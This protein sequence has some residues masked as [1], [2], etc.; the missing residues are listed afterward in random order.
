MKPL[1]R[2]TNLIAALFLTSGMCGWA[3]DIYV[4]N[5][6]TAEIYKVDAQGNRTLFAATASTQP[7]GMAF[8]ARGNLYVSIGLGGIIQ[9]FDP[10]G[11][12]ST[13]GNAPLNQPDSLAFDKSGNLY[14]AN[15]FGN[16]IIKL[17]PQGNWSV[18]SDFN[19]VSAA[20][21]LAFDSKGNLFGAF[22]GANQLLKFDAYGNQ[23]L[24]AWTP[25][26][27]YYLTADQND[28]LYASSQ[29][30]PIYKIDPRGVVSTFVNST[31]VAAGVD[32]D[33]NGNLYA[34]YGN[35]IV[36]YDS[37]GNASVFASGL[38]SYLGGIA[39]QVV[40]EPAS[41]A[42]LILGIAALRPWRRLRSPGV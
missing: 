19:G 5:W 37:H 34:I 8:D 13:F 22:G 39:I 40:P 38:P 1:L 32:C 15:E 36:K 25:S 16:N 20:I 2:K 26:S 42:T 9:K 29:T 41:C 4:S 11:H 10:Q 6:L 21:G 18:F 17:D 35:Q 30:G 33:S 23:S 28:N 14:V 31:M 3:D 24:F 7:K 27:C 12:A